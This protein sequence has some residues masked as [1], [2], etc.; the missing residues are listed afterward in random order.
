MTISKTQTQSRLSR[1]SVRAFALAFIV[2]GTALPL[3]ASAATA[4]KIT[5]SVYG[6]RVSVNVPIDLL[7]TEDGKARL[8][9]ALER[10]A[11]KSCKI[12][13]PQRLG[14]SVSVKRCTSNLMDEFVSELD[15]A[16]ITALH[17]AA[18]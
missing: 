5:A 1:G 18:T 15:D 14:R 16:G 12:T 3:S 13:I 9:R 17:V 8:Y 2:A 10:K 7:T 11:V 4:Q 6:E